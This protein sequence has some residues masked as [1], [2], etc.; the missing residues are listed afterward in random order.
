MRESAYEV[1]WPL[2]K[3]AYKAVDSTSRVSDF[4]GKTI[5]ELCDWLFRGEVIFPMLRELLRKRYPGVKFVDYTVF[6]NI[7]GG[8]QAEVTAALPDLLA[9]H[10]C[11]AVI[12]GVGG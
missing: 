3:L 6:G 11:D 8:K 5:C 4:S 10:G 9:K 7:H 2:G 1:V 12:S